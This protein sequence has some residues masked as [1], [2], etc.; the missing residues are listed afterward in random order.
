MFGITPIGSTYRPKHLIYNIGALIRNALS[1]NVFSL[2]TTLVWTSSYIIPRHLHRV[3]YDPGM[4]IQRRR[5]CAN[6][7]VRWRG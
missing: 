5:L 6:R 1:L 3:I 2:G 4:M 7:M